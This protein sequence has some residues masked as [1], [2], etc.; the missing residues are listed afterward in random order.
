MKTEIRRSHGSK[1]PRPK[2]APIPT[3]RSYEEVNP[4]S[5][6]EIDEKRLLSHSFFR[7]LNKLFK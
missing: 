5:E 3:V 6:K 2:M 4:P 1:T 7:S